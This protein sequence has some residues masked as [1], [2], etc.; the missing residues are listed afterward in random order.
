MSNDGLSIWKL[1][2]NKYK[3]YSLTASQMTPPTQLL[4]PRQSSSYTIT[5][6]VA[7]RVEIEP[8]VQSLIDLTNSKDAALRRPSMAIPSTS[9]LH[10]ASIP[11]SPNCPRLSYSPSS[12]P[13]PCVVQSLRRFA[14]MP[15][16]KNIL[17]RLDYDRFKTVHS[18]FLP[19]MFDGNVMYI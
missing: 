9:I 6:P 11:K 12:Q 14:S 4:T 15:G 7:A 5:T 3:V 10:P 2:P 8:K 16:R 17:K 19:P 18:E 1:N 13:S